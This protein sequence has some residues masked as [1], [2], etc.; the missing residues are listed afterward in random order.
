M[1]RRSGI[2]DEQI[3]ALPGFRTSTLFSAKEK[4]ALECSEAMTSTPVAVS[5]EVF[6][7]LR[8]H[9]NDD[10]LLEL[11]ASIAHENFRARFYHALEIGS[12]GLYV[13][14]LPKGK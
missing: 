6:A 7:R 10:Q 8:E 13:C 5:D 3:L 4:A 2:T 14:A 11:T 12:D 9:F 1:S